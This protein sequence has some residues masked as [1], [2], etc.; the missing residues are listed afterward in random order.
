[1]S[2][3]DPT[4]PGASASRSGLGTL[5]APPRSGQRSWRAPGDSP[6]EDEARVGLGERGLWVAAALMVLLWGVR[7]WGYNTEATWSPPLA[8]LLVLGGTAGVLW[9]L[10]GVDRCS[11]HQRR[12]VGW[13]MVALALVAFGVWSYFQV[14]LAPAYGTDEIAFDQYAAQLA[15]HGLNP[16]LHSMAP[17]FSLFHVS[18]D[19]ATFT[20][21]GAPVTKLSYPALSFLVYLPLLVLG[22]HA[23]AAIWLNVAAWGLG[24]VLLYGLLPLPLAPAAVVVG[25]LSLG[26]AYAVGGVTGVLFLPLLLGAVLG[27]DAFGRVRGWRSWRGPVLLGL[28]MAI[29]QTPWPVL[30]FFLVGIAVEANADG[31]ARLA[32][33]RTGQYLL[34]CAGAFLVPNVLYLVWSPRAWL[35][36]VLAPF[37]AH[38]V[39]AGFGFV[40]LVVYDGLG[41]GSLSAFTVAAVLTL[42]ALLAVYLV[43]Y[44]RLKPLAVLLPGVAYLVS[45]RSFASHVV[46]LIPAAVLAAVTVRP[47]P[48]IV[49]G[50]RHWR[51]V[52]LGAGALTVGPLLWALGSSPPLALQ[53]VSIHT[54]GQLATVDRVTVAVTNRTG[55]RLRPRFSVEEGGTVTAFWAAQGGAPTIG[56]G[57]TAR[58]T[59]LAPNF[60]A[61]PAITGGFDVVAFTSSPGTVSRS[62]PYLPTVLHL[63]L[64]PAAVNH[65]VLLGSTV[66]LRAE[67]LNRFDQ[68]VHQADV[69]VYLGQIIY[70]QRG[71]LY[72]SAT[73]N[74]S[75]PGQT[76]VEALTNAQ[77]VATFTI[78][79]LTP[80]PDPVYFEANLVNSQSYYPYGYSNIVDVRFVRAAG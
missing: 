73:V 56:P 8:V 66:T 51:A 62:S 50:E 63:A 39:P 77:G 48:R 64:L 80:E 27:W 24:T 47:A 35:E 12:M 29:K 10:V 11:R 59:L 70:A 42:L 30:L 74:G 54:T 9:A 49:L 28:A 58:I 37:S 16:Y 7:L 55:S 41:G 31:G 45:D 78:Q 52:T 76:P 61:Q 19:G 22:L 43:G 15:L 25:S 60:E 65:P 21:S 18:P 14:V 69:P 2:M 5:L 1:V 72:A 6:A 68:P 57:Q 34:L 53:V 23:Q 13:A 40:A 67:L 33:R 79:D 32:L 26:V 38:L 75:L 46:A 71:L 20:L 17:A 44:R 4:L 36:G 3:G